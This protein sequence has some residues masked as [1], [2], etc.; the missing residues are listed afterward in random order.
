MKNLVFL[1]FNGQAGALLL[2]GTVGSTVY[3]REA[4]LLTPT[5]WYITTHGGAGFLLFFRAVGLSCWR[6]WW[7]AAEPP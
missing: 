4:G 1:L 3:L 6:A 2:S 7:C 5:K